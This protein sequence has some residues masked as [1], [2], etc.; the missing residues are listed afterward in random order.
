MDDKDI[1]YLTVDSGYTNRGPLVLFK[2]KPI[3]KLKVLKKP[4]VTI[5]PV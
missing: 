1:E 2:P 4:N 3:K 5:P